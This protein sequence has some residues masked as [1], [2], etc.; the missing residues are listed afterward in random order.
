MARLEPAQPGNSCTPDDM[1]KNGFGLVIQRMPHCHFLRAD[2]CGR[3][4]QETVPYLTRSLLER[5]SLPG[6]IAFDISSFHGGRNAETARQL[7][8]ITGVGSGFFSAQHVVQMR[9]V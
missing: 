4:C 6:A 8:Y 1:E 5:E 3:L 7:L 2:F 9:H